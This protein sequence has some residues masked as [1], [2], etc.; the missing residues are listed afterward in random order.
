M[1]PHIRQL[2]IQK[3]PQLARQVIDRGT[4]RGAA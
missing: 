4:T 1:A 3:M 2:A